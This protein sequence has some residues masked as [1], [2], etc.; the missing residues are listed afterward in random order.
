MFS[1][2]PALLQ[3]TMFAHL[4]RASNVAT[5]LNAQRFES[6]ARILL[7]SREDFRKGEI[8]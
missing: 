5:P 6:S 2:I 8:W 1:R 3:Y 4:F 7:L